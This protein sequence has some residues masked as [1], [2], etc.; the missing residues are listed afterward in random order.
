LLQHAKTGEMYAS[1]GGM[2]A[3]RMGAVSA[4]AEDDTDKL[5]WV[6][7]L[8]PVTGRATGGKCSWDRC[9]AGIA[10]RAEMQHTTWDDCGLFLSNGFFTSRNTNDPF[11][12]YSQKR[13]KKKIT[14]H[15]N[16]MCTVNRQY[17]CRTKGREMWG[18]TCLSRDMLRARS[19]VRAS[20][21]P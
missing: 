14:K 6:D 19:A 20:R 16:S 1:Y 2:R 12:K 3:L 15:Q 7:E 8:P 9:G 18:T 4:R 13:R 21:C 5:S 17:K 11:D 10:L